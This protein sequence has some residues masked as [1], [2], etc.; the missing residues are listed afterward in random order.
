APGAAGSLRSE[1][2]G[3]HPGGARCCAPR[4]EVMRIRKRW[5]A[6]ISLAAWIVPACGE[7]HAVVRDRPDGG[8]GAGD[9]GVTFLACGGA[10]PRTYDSAAFATNAKEEI[11]LLSAYDALD[12]RMASAEGA[13]TSIVTTTDLAAL[14][15]QGT[16]SLRA[17]STTTVQAI[18]DGYLTA[19]GDAAG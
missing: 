2:A 8:A 17:A 4:Q 9:A 5:L 16:P 11:D 19:F 7:D 10:V 6:A 18:V 3:Q 15:A 14:Y 1:A 13:G 12:A